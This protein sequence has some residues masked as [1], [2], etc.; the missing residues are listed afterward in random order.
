MDQ[1]L[2]HYHYII[3]EYIIFLLV[4]NINTQIRNIPLSYSTQIHHDI[5][6]TLL[7]KINFFLT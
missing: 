6:A 5:I 1:S 2:V 7:L 3:T 4:G